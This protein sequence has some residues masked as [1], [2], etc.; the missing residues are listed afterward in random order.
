MTSTLKVYLCENF[1]AAA[2]GKAY[3]ID[4]LDNVRRTHHAIVFIFSMTGSFGSTGFD[5]VIKIT[6]ICNFFQRALTQ[7]SI[8]VF[9]EFRLGPWQ[10]AIKRI[11]RKTLW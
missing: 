1:F 3:H 6:G 9:G 4:V 7:S 2:I 8:N 10:I 11:T 5:I